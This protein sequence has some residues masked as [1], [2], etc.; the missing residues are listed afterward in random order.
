MY[1]ETVNRGDLFTYKPT[2][3][4]CLFLGYIDES[5]KLYTE[6]FSVNSDLNLTTKWYF[7][8]T[9]ISD[10]HEYVDLGLPSG[11]KWATYNMGALVPEAFGELYKY[12]E[13]TPN[14]INSSWTNYKWSNGS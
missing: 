8:S 5:N 10:T 7:N 2:K 9:E 11:I 6:Q 4:N 13:T 3:D 14:I 12:G 1:T